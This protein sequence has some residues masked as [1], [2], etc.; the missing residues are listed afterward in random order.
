[1]NEYFS[2]QCKLI[3][4]NSTLPDFEYVTDKRIDSVCFT[5]SDLLRLIRN[6]NTNKA[7]GSDGI[8]GKMLVIADSSVV[9]PL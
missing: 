8:S 2:E 9:K 7:A 3:I 4:N 6:L 1:M 5:D